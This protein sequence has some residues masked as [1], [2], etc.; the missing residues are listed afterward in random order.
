MSSNED[1]NKCQVCGEIN[2]SG[3][4][5]CS[6]CGA[7]LKKV[8]ET[9]DQN[10]PGGEGPGI[11]G[12]GDN[13]DGGETKPSQTEKVISKRNLFYL[14]LG[15]LFLAGLLL[16]SGGEFDEPKVS[17]EAPKSAG[18]AVDLSSLNQIDSLERSVSKN[19]GDKESL[20]QLAHL[21]NDS[22][23]KEKAVVRYE[24]Y[25]KL[26]PRNADV[27]VDLGVCYYETGRNKEAIE[28]MEK[29]LTIQPRHQIANLNLGI[30]N[31][32]SGLK[33]KAVKYWKKAVQIDSTNE[34]GRKAKE[35]IKSH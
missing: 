31:M 10:S 1:L 35:L 7:V 22:G 27:I 24:E 14:I 28:V 23:F 3:S 12:R 26:D 18:T 16:Y 20:L 2:R 6:G 34:I 15:L 21:L 25:L 33:D 5:Y 32:A 8:K 19:P 13:R 30:V 17:G 9:D 29:A 4:N 11:K